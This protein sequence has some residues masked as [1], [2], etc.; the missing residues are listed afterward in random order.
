M[1]DLFDLKTLT[2]A[3]WAKL[4]PHIGF[5][6]VVKEFP[7]DDSEFTQ[8]LLIRRIPNEQLEEEGAWTI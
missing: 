6:R 7:P 5:I 4:P 1:T 3:D 8:E 2:P